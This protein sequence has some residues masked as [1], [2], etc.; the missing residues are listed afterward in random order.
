M[1]KTSRHTKNSICVIHK[2]KIMKTS[3]NSTECMEP[4]SRYYISFYAHF[5]V[6]YN[7][8]KMQY[9]FSTSKSYCSKCTPSKVVT[10]C[11]QKMFRSYRLAIH[12]H[13]IYKVRW[14]LSYPEVEKSIGTILFILVTQSNVKKM[15]TQK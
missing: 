11:K 4:F 8:A 9:F 15:Y 3:H 14:G 1:N 7:T 12:S 10:L 5:K 13:Y 6:T 2:H